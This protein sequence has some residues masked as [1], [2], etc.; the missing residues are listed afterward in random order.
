MHR[1]LAIGAATVLALAL[2]REAAAWSWPADGAVVRSFAL[3]ADVYAAGQHRGIDVAGPDGSA[4]KAPA[5]GVVSFSGSLPTYGRGVTILTAD[6]YAVTL[7]HL[8]TIESREGRHR[9]RRRHSRHD[10]RQRHARAG[11][12]ERPP[13]DPPSVRRRGICRSTRA[14]PAASGTGACSV[15]GPGGGRRAGFRAGTRH[16]SPAV[17]AGT[18]AGRRS[19][20][21]AGSS[22]TAVGHRHGACGGGNGRVGGVLGDLT[23]GIAGE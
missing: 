20:A 9:R 18:L 17:A 10:G 11:R 7:V 23:G 1:I 22:G 19:G 16:G 5:A 3:G 13:R 12:A 2:S 14:A 8:G 4:V 15:P 21:G 6:G